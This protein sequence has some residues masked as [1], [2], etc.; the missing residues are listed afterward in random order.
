MIQSMVG[1][2]AA[3]GMKEVVPIVQRPQQA[4]Q[5]AHIDVGNL[6]KLL[7]PS[8]ELCIADGQ[9][10]VRAK[11]RK[12]LRVQRR[13]RDRPMMPEVVGGIVSGAHNLDVEFLQ[14]CLS[15]QPLRE[16]GV[17]PL[18]DGRRGCLIQQFVDSE[19]AL[20]FEVRPMVERIAQGVRNGSRPG[21]KFL[22]G[23]GIPRNEFF[24]DTVGPHSPPFV[25]VSL[26]PDLEQIGEPP[27]FSN[28]AG[29][30]MTVI[31]EDGLRSGELMIKTP[32]SIVRQ[33]KIFGEEVGHETRGWTF[34]PVRNAGL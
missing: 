15:G 7:D 22:V 3:Q 33:K 11:R 1:E 18:P 4:A 13:L 10:L 27:I 25:V 34:D 29:R 21:Q 17:R 2:A 9:S 8:Q 14:N 16:R 32:G 19:V 6:R 26:Q 23:S 20:Q 30:K 12:H 5:V 24:R 31:V 28:V